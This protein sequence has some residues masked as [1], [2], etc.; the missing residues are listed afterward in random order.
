[1]AALA[2]E[3]AKGAKLA[4]KKAWKANKGRPKRRQESIRQVKPGMVIGGQ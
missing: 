1:M 4:R 2:G 3:K